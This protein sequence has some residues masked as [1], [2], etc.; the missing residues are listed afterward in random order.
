MKRF[1][2]N[3]DCRIELDDFIIIMN[4]AK[5]DYLNENKFNHSNWENSNLF[6]N[7]RDNYNISHRNDFNFENNHHKDFYSFCYSDNR[8]NFY[9]KKKNENVYLP[10]LKKLSPKTVFYQLAD[11]KQQAST[12]LS[13][14][15]G[16]VF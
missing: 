6:K 4:F 1:D 16:P 11:R 2:I 7:I 3:G 13:D 10:R 12:I 9:N 5:N 8:S 14:F 15:L